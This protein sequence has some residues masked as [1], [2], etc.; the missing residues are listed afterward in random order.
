MACFPYV[1]TSIA[2]MHDLQLLTEL[3]RSIQGS[4]RG[5][6][7]LDMIAFPNDEAD[8]FRK[9]REAEMAG[10]HDLNLKIVK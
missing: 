7:Y 9:F 10:E 8:L 1:E 3:D 2:A 5:V 4:K 6:M